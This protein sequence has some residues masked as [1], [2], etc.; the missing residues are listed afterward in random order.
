MWDSVPREAFAGVEIIA[1]GNLGYPPNAPLTKPASSTLEQDV[2][3]VASFIPPDSR[4]HLFSHSYGGLVALQLVKALGA[5][6]GSAFLFEPVLFGALTRSATSDA[7]A[8]AEAKS[9][10]ESPSFFAEETGGD[11]AWLTAF[12]DYWN[13]PGS[14]AR[15]PEGARVATRALSWKMFREVREVF[16]DGSNFED[17]VI[18]APTT[19]V[20]AERSPAAARAM[21]DQLARVNPGAVVKELRGTGH[22]APLTHPKVLAE[23]VVEHWRRVWH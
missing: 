18:R 16:F 6:L 22:M 8:L 11:E 12:I 17:H 4:V 7:A 15:M 2:R 14:W 3:H 19:L 13:R 5:R 21:V 9:F 10:A 20:K 1:P 23:A